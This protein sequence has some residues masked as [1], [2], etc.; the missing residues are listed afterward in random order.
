MAPPTAAASGSASWCISSAATAASASWK[1]GFHTRVTPFFRSGELVFATEM[2]EL[3]AQL[4]GFPRGRIDGPN[5]LAY[6]LTLRPGIPVYENFSP[7]E[8]VAERVIWQRGEPV[9]LA[10]H[11]T[12]AYT[13]G[14]LL[15][16]AYG[17]TL[18]LRDWI[19]EGDPAIGA[20]EIVREA[21][22]FAR[23][24]VEIVAH[25]QHF[26]EWRNVGLRQ[27]LSAIPA[28][29]GKGLD[30]AKG[31]AYLRQ[32]LAR[33]TRTAAAVQ[34][35]ASAHWTL[36]AL[37]AGYAQ[38]PGKNEPEGG[39]HRTLAEGLEAALGLMAL[40]LTDNDNVAWSYT[41]DGRRY[42]R[43][44]SAFEGGASARNRWARH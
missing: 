39:V 24:Q 17:R 19:R 3:R 32:E 26:D 16:V 25:P 14:V 28:I 30:P 5:A 15:Q 34:V 37:S 1:A 6:A 29:P 44:A 21:S 18:I 23:S 22:M 10:M 13:T 9:Y 2:P 31:R 27:A 11:A 41:Q 43:Y 7:H 35:D 38:K 40:H 12:G 20:V 8:H 33:M 42:R 4:L 36:A